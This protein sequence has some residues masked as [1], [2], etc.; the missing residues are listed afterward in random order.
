MTRMALL[1]A[2][3]GALA[4]GAG[5]AAAQQFTCPKKGGEITF[6][7][8]A[9]VNSLDLVASGA[10]S[11][12][13][14]ALQIQDSLMTRDEN[15][16]P[17]PQLAQSVEQS[18]DGKTYVFK[19]WPGV[20]FH[21][22]KPLTT[23]DVVAS[24]DRFKKI[25]INRG[26]LDV[27]D[28][29]EATDPLT[30][31]IHMKAPQPT[32]LENLSSFGAPPVIVPAEIANAAPMQLQPIGTGPWQFV[33]F[34]PDSHVKLKRY[35]GYVADTR[36]KD[37]DGFGGYR[38]ACFDSVVYRIV[39]EPGARVAGLETGELQGVEDVPTKSQERLKQNKNVVLKQM[40]NFWI[41]I[42]IPNFSAPPT[43]NLKFRQAVQ[44]AL[45]MDEILE[46]ATD[47]AY[48]LNPAFLYPG[49]NFYTEIGK[50]AYNQKNPAK[51]K[52]L[53][54]EAGYKGEETILL[55]N[56][57]YTSMY[58]AAL[59]MS[60]QLKAVGVNVKLVVLD[61]PASSQFQANNT[62]GWNIYFTG[63]ATPPAVGGAEALR[64]LAAP[65]ST[66]KP[67]TPAD[68]DKEFDAAFREI[69][70]NSNMQARAA[71]FAKAQARVF[72]Q[73]MALPFGSLTKVQAVRANVQN[74]RPFRIPRMSN[75]YFSG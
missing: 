38:V 56:R 37:I 72:D 24:F 54:A 15:S 17:I 22:G 61:W 12:R 33:E 44:A 73:V 21:N 63:W 62:A 16:N 65:Y 11:S 51:A 41:Q 8:E 20:K 13:D 58:N 67:K 69:E 43:D 40:N 75:V 2:S 27:V 70:N 7:M 39:T 28:N 5:Q 9:K 30:F 3:V 68:A 55:T 1:L 14:I 18:Q 36:Y 47:G 42:S 64:N 71:G 66:Y 57:D 59:V 48:R 10:V 29:Y 32:F 31:V 46:A 26:I 6:A 53:L 4:L 19:L 74:F 23:T 35:D 52:K 45:D 60:E 50:E 49:Q 34:V 25:G